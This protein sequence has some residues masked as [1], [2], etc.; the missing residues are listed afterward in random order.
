MRPTRPPHHADP[1]LRATLMPPAPAD[2]AQGTVAP[3]PA[4]SREGTSD[5]A[6]WHRSTE[7]RPHNHLLPERS[8]LPLRMAEASSGHL[9]GMSHRTVAHRHRRP[10]R[11]FDRQPAA[12][13]AIASR[14]AP[15]PVAQTGPAQ[16]TPPPAAQA[17]RHRRFRRRLRALHLEERQVKDPSRP[18]PRRDGVKGTIRNF[19]DHSVKVAELYGGE[20]V[21]C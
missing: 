16:G 19:T 15:P 8:G 7:R 1:P 17:T 18:P 10:R 9:R 21:S 6:R 11:H 13:P 12:V 2:P 4:R 20:N 5:T 3:V 14:A